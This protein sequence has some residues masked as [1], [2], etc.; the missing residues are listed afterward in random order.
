LGSARAIFLSYDYAKMYNG[1]FYLSFED[2]DYKNKKPRLEFYDSI[3]EHLKWLGCNWD[4]EIIQSDRLEIYYEFAEGLLKAGNAYICTCKRDVFQAKSKVGQSCSCRIL[5]I[6]KNLVRWRNMLDGKYGEGKAVVRIKTDLGHNNPAVRDWP[7]LRIIDSKKYPHPRVGSKYNVWP[8]YNF[9]TGIDDHLMGITHVIRGKEHLTNQVRQEYMYRHLGWR[10]PEAIHYGRLKI[11]GASLS[12][13]EIVKGLSSGLYKY[14]D[15]P[16]L[17]TLSALRKRGITSEAI[18]KLIIDVGPKPQDVVLSWKNLYSYNKK[19]IDSKSKRYFFVVDPLE[20]AIKNM[21]HSFN[22][23]IPFHPDNYEM[24]FRS[25][26]IIPIRGVATLWISKNDFGLLKNN[27]V[28]RLMEL[29]NV[30]IKRIGNSKV[31]GSFESEA[32]SEAKN[33]GYPLIQ[34]VCVKNSFPSEVVMPDNAIIKGL[35]E[36]SCKKLTQNEI[37]QFVRFGFV[38]VFDIKEKLLVYFTHY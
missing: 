23:R 28:I 26:Q 30:K 31:V 10:Y 7:A 17:A 5:S 27:K 35:A 16:R 20:L 29:F 9:S 22:V 32:Y 8:L 38:K 15:D 6:K 34:W 11:T 37:I 36:E 25:I 24:G 33:R 12:K 19:I 1:R 2:K 3:R 13:S 21:P 4:E 18:H 14:W